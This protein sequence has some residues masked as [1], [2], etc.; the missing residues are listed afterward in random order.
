MSE[1][2]R[3]QLNRF[4]SEPASGR[5]P[6]KDVVRDGVITAGSFVQISATLGELVLAQALIGQSK[7]PDPRSDGEKR[8]NAKNLEK[9]DT[10]M[11][12]TR[13]KDQ[14]KGETIAD[15]RT[16]KEKAQEAKDLIERDKDKNT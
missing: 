13:G 10:E 9:R 5:R 12:E 15:P 4:N 11:D 1:R 16:S 7:R 3:R 14:G 2:L 8:R 6:I